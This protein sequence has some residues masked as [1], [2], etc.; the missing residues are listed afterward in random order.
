MIRRVLT[1]NPQEQIWDEIREKYLS[2]RMFKSLQAVINAAAD[3]LH[4]L[5]KLPD[6]LKS[7]THRTWI[8]TTE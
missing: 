3:G 1:L 5:E 8:L 2:N 4:A 6:K 7:L